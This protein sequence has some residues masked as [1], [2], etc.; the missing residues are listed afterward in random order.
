MICELWGFGANVL[1]KV[2]KCSNALDRHHLINRSKFKRG[3]A[4]DKYIEK[5]PEIFFSDVCGV[6]NCDRWADTPVARRILLKRK[7]DTW[8]IEYVKS[9]INGMPWKVAHPELSYKGIMSA[10]LPK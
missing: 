3:S 7:V 6:H 1:G 9:V 5:H 4:V 8:G 10:P 2:I